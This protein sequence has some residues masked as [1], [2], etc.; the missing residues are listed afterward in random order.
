MVI[1][2]TILKKLD[3]SG[4]IEQLTKR[5]AGSFRLRLTLSRQFRKNRINAVFPFLR[6]PHHGLAQVVSI[7]F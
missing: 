7:S 3:E 1:N 4:F 6:Q 2:H 5:W